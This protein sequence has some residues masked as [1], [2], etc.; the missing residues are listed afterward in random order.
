M[1]PTSFDPNVREHPQPSRPTKRPMPLSVA[2]SPSWAAPPLVAWSVPPFSHGTAI[3]VVSPISPTPHTFGFLTPVRSPNS[4]S[5]SSTRPPRWVIALAK[6]SCRPV[7]RLQLPRGQPLSLSRQ[8]L[9][10]LNVFGNSAVA[11]GSIRL[12]PTDPSRSIS[13]EW[14]GSVIFGLPIG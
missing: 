13:T 12:N 1:V 2:L 10:P 9:H 3:G 11:H 14:V 8:V 7:R 5:L 6:R 4:L